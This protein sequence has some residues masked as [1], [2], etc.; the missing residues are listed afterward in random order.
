MTSVSHP[1]S[2]RL[3]EQKLASLRRKLTL[4]LAVHGL[5]RWLLIVGGLILSDVLID[6]TFEMDFAQRVIML[7]VMVVIAVYYFAI[8]V[9]KPLL[10]RLT[11][12][13]LI[14]QVEQ[15][16]SGAKEQIL[17]SLQLARTTDQIDT[18]SSKQLINATIESG[19]AKAQTID[20]ENTLDRKQHKKDLGLLSATGLLLM[21]L[22]LGTIAS[23]FLGTWFSRNIMLTNRQWPQPTYLEIAGAENGKMILPLG[24]KHRQI[25]TISEDSAVTDVEV[26]LEVQGSGG[27]RTIYPMKRT[28]KLDG[29]EWVFEL[30]VT[31]EFQFLASASNGIATAW[32]EVSYVQPPAVVDLRLDVALPSYTG[33]PTERLSGT[34]PHSVLQGSQLSIAATANKP[35]QSATLVAAGRTLDLPLTGSDTGDTQGNEAT[36]NATPNGQTVQI[37]I[38]EP[39]SLQTLAGGDYELE[40]VDVTGLKN[41][42]RSKFAITIVEDQPPKLRAELLGISGLV[43]PRATIPMSYQ[44]VDD[45]GLSQMFFDCRWRSGDSDGNQSDLSVKQ[46]NFDGLPDQRPAVSVKDVGVLQLEM[47]G[48]EPGTTLRINV[49]A[50]DNRPQSPGTGR[51]QDFPLQVV[52]EEELRADLLRRE[53]EQRK[54]F[55]QIYRSQLEL[56]AEIEAVVASQPAIGVTFETFHRQREAKMISMIRDQ[57]GIGTSVDRTANRFEEFLV[58]VKNNRLDEAEND[59]MPSQRIERRFDEKIIRPLRWLDRELISVATRN[60]DNC[61]RV[62]QNQMELNVAVD[63]TIAV[64]QQVLEAMKKILDAMNN[65]ETFQ[66]ILNEM[67]ELKR[68]T[69]SIGQSIDKIKA[70]QT[71]TDET[72]AEGIFDE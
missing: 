14:Y 55:E 4:W 30:N 38:P 47:L 26:N 59:L 48:L 61:R 20:F 23:P 43:T 32:V 68:T 3:I 31:N 35:L 37:T 25:V 65:S 56:M 63:Q 70:N 6:R 58:E 1:P 24:S 66:E 53:I 50:D 39:D 52:S 36:A 51:S 13:A 33:L 17:A 60:M 72:D 21:V 15:K 27:S 57:K 42:R 49:S 7:A 54:S 10:T 22:G 34:G 67:L 12:D 8:K 46:I 62:E 11:D 45:Y 2:T 41:I 16:N 9:V 28:G 71:I 29:R 44:A 69:D 19:I 64:Q 18:G 40:L 5:G